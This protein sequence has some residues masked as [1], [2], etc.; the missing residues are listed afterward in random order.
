MFFLTALTELGIWKETAM[1]GGMSAWILDKTFRANLKVVLIGGGEPW[2]MAPTVEPDPNRRDVAYLDQYAQ[3]R[4]DTVLH[5]LV[6]SSQQTGVSLDAVNILLHSGLMARD[7][8]DPNQHIITKSGFQFLL[9]E[10]SS[11]VWYFML[12]YLDTVTMRNMSLIE[13]LNFLFQLSFATL[14]KGRFYSK[15]KFSIVILTTFEFSRQ[16]HDAKIQENFMFRSTPNP[17]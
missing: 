6:S 3:E 13:C 9:M 14:G 11:Q 12:Q 15:V 7:T 1:S 2:V 16:K 10:T 17:K 4:W 5:Y 8:D